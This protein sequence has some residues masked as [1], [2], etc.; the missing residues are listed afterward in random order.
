MSNISAIFR[1][2][3]KSIIYKHYIYM[4]ERMGQGRL[5]ATEEK[6][7]ES[8]IGTNKIILCSDYSAPPLF[9]N[10]Q[11]RSLACRERGLSKT[12]C[13]LWYTLMLSLL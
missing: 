13:Q 1:T 2:E 9:R 5:T 11:K 3:T 4:R 10:L 8:R 6:S 7:I 12:R